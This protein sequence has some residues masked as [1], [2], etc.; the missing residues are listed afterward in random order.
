MAGFYRLL[1][2]L[3]YTSVLL[4]PK[5]PDDERNAFLEVRA[6]TGGDEA[7]LE[8]LSLIH[9][10]AELVQRVLRPRHLKEDPGCQTGKGAERRARQRASALW[11]DVYKRQRGGLS[12]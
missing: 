12:G 5:D 8:F 11:V 6:G 4:L 7:A 2:C 9:I 3:L 1:S 10:S